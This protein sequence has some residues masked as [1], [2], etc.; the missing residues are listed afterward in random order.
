M[1]QVLAFNK[2]IFS[3]L[4]WFPTAPALALHLDHF[5]FLCVLESLYLMWM[6]NWDGATGVV[7]ASVPTM[8]AKWSVKIRMYRRQNSFCSSVKV[9][10]GVVVRRVRQ[11]HTVAS[12]HIILLCTPGQFSTPGTKVNHW[13]VQRATGALLGQ[14]WQAKW[15]STAVCRHLV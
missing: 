13:D 5:T 14:L 12:C 8:P 6:W 9:L 4:R 7:P 11:C 15:S 1:S 3:I 2:S 10:Y